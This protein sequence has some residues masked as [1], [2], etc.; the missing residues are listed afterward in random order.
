MSKKDDMVMVI[1]GKEKGKSGKVIGIFPGKGRVVVES[2]NTIKRHTRPGPKPTL[3][4]V[5]LK[6]KL[7]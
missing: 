7:P 5:L 2:L 3:K 6:K 4:G 1:A